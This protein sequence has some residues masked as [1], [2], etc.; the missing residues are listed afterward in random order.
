MLKRKKNFTL[1]TVGFCLLCAL[2]LCSCKTS[3]ELAEKIPATPPPVVNQAQANPSAPDQNDY[4]EYLKFFEKVYT[5]METN[6]Y[7]PIH[8]GAYDEFIK[9]FD[10]K[11]YAE[12]KGDDKTINF[13]KWRSAAFLVDFLK[14]P[15]DTFSA[16][17]PPKF[18]EAYENKVLGK[19]IDLGIEGT[20]G[21]DGYSVTNIEPRSDAY[22][23]GL[24]IHDII[25]R[26]AE[27]DVKAMSEE[28]LKESLNPLENSKVAI[29]YLVSASREAKTIE[30][31]SQEY[32]RQSVFME[33]VR[34]PGV[35]C[36]QIKT[37]NRKT[38][39]DMFRYLAWIEKKAPDSGLILD[40]RGNPG[41]PPL[42]ARE[43]S[44]FFLKPN[45][46]FAYFQKKGQPKAVL[47][48]PAIPVQF[49]FDGPIV[50]LINKE[51]GSAAELFSGILQNKGR[52]EL[53]GTNSAGKV[54]LKSMFNL[55]DESMLLL[56]TA[57]GH[58]PD[59]NVF[60]FDGLTPDKRI[61]Q[62]DAD[63]INLAALYLN[64]KKSN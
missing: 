36:L 63:L 32:F 64:S 33:P 45:D 37:F 42:A 50:I 2:S 1:Q 20:L 35:Y 58:F 46:E 52:A 23:Q 30:V 6:Y 54:L 15:E 41:G 7:Q 56:V 44:A 31:M 49:H 11:I 17:I 19:R 14:D 59:G 55:E 24:R 53:M 61:E 43:I 12:L 25:L 22:M 47:D 60:S 18:A 39:E 57:R 27:K 4:Q 40:L 3:T 10:S 13:I 26:I 62:P 48:V 21:P 51:S 38:S 34:V 8:R 9:K 5:T 28:E 16:L 29:D